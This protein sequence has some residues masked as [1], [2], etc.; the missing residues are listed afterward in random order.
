MAMK[1]DKSISVTPRLGWS[2]KEAAARIG[3]SCGLVRKLIREGKL[4][5][6]NIN[7]RVVI[8][9]TDLRALL[10]MTDSEN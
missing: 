3:C 9:E 5:S 8:L 4:P 6:R 1:K 7:R 2:P 10:R